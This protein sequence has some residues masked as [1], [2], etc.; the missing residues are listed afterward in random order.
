MKIRASKPKK[1]RLELDWV[2]SWR[3]LKRPM[4]GQWMPLVLVGGVFV[5]AGMFM[6]VTVRRPQPWEATSATVIM[7][8]AVDATDGL[9]IKAKEGGPFPV[10]LE[11]GQC[12]GYIEQERMVL[13]NESLYQNR[14]QPKLKEIEYEQARDPFSMDQVA[15][16]PKRAMKEPPAMGEKKSR[17][18][19]QVASLNAVHDRLIPSEL[20]DFEQGVEE[21]WQGGALRYLLRLDASGHV[22]D[23]VGMSQVDLKPVSEWLK[24]VKFVVDE[25]KPVEWMT[26]EVGFIQE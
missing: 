20:P 4:L 19:V 22:V 2:F 21:S 17:A 3:R 5:M 15:M 18:K 8:G 23:C 12:G 24:Q 14:Y 13:E 11:L 10:R 16:L 25:K 1:K 6:R 7:A 26:V 9:A